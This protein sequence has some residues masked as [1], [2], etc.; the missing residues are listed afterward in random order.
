MSSGPIN[1]SSPGEPAAG[2]TAPDPSAV[3]DEL[4]R[5]IDEA[6]PKLAVMTEEA[7]RRHDGEHWSPRQIIGHLI[8]SAANNHARFVR[9]QIEEDLVFPGYDQEEWVALEGYD[10]APWSELVELWQ[11]YNRHLARVIARIDPLEW[12]RPRARHNF[13]RIGFSPIEASRL[14]SLAWLVVDYLTHLRHHLDQIE[15]AT[16]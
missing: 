9:G 15:R 5:I 2:A 7:S 8:D 16:S 12:S 13:D 4:R 3:A 10:D 14:G 1:T 6:A 11:A